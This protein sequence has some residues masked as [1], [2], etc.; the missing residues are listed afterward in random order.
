[1]VFQSEVVAGDLVLLDRNSHKSSMQ[2][3]QL[4]NAEPI[5][6]NVSMRPSFISHRAA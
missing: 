2:A 1:M 6:L 4:C 5:Y 3:I